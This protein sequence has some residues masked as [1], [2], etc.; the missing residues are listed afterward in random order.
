MGERCL[1]SVAERYMRV[2]CP[3][4]RCGALHGVK[5][6]DKRCG[7]LHGGGVSW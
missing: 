2:G 3:G 4:K 7:A 5:C 6:P 1:V